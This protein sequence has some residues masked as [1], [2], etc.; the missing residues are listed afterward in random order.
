MEYSYST[1]AK[2]VAHQAFWD[3]I[4]NGQASVEIKD[5]DE[6][7]LS[8]IPLA[9]GSVSQETGQ[10]TIQPDGRD[11]EAAQSGEAYKAEILDG[12]GAVH[13]T[14]PCQQGTSSVAGYC[15]LTNT[16]IEQGD[17]VEMQSLT[18]G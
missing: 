8:T 3:L 15:V 5:A 7:V 13:L 17:P 9:S 2:V 16:T 14:M 4:S 12:Q 18:I 10:L 6:V 1:E 11:D